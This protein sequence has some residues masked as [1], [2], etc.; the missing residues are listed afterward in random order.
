MV[1]DL[2]YTRALLFDPESVSKL[3]SSKEL[4]MSALPLDDNSS[5]AHV[6][7]K[8][9]LDAF[10]GLLMGRLECFCK[11]IFFS[12]FLLFAR[13]ETILPLEDNVI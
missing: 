3:Q 2:L 5:L 13:C 6:Y 4:R 9:G 11:S 8:K 7:L 1:D 10:R 12:N